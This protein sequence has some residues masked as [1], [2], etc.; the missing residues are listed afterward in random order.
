VKID[1]AI[2]RLVLDGF[3]VRPFERPELQAAVESELARLL[4][5]RGLGSELRDGGAT[6]RLN[7]GTVQLPQADPSDLGRS[8]ATAAYQGLSR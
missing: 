5:Q 2:E 4:G 7:G 3:D 1:V 6:P 8:I